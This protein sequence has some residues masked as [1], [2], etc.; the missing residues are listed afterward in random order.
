MKLILSN[1]INLENYL[2]TRRVIIILII[3]M[4]FFITDKIILIDFQITII[5]LYKFKLHIYMEIL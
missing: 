2:R 4:I 5:C 1:N 3:R